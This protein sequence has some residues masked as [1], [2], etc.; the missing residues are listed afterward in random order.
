MDRETISRLEALSKVELR[1]KERERLL[2]ELARIVGYAAEL[3]TLHREGGDGERAGG[4]PVE[5]DGEVAG[6]ARLEAGSELRDDV[7]GTCLQRDTVL[8]GAPDVD[9]AGRFYRVPRVIP[10]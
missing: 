1:P 10:R 7:P 4:T 5:K 6:D 2:P 8:D 3:R 9:E